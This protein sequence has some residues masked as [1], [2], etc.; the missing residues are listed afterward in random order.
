MEIKK[1]QEVGKHST[2]FVSFFL[3]KADLTVVLNTIRFVFLYIL[4]VLYYFFI[5]FVFIFSNI[6]V[7]LLVL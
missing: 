3:L 5:R 1:M 7:L 6:I 2:C 4:L